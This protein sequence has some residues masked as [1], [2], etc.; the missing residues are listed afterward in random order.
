MNWPFVNWASVNGAVND[1]LPVDRLTAFQHNGTL[2]NVKSRA[3][4]F[5]DN[6]G[7]VLLRIRDSMLARWDFGE[8]V[9][10]RRGSERRI[11]V[12]AP[13]ATILRCFAGCRLSRWQ[14]WGRGRRIAREQ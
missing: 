7:L 5:V 9:G 2:A 11:R 8:I 4:M 10:R 1:R 3:G 6:K 13:R 12:T 14:P